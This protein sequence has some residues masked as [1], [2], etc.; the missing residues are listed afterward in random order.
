[1]RCFVLAAALLISW[2]ASQTGASGPEAKS[3][4]STPNAQVSS[5]HP[6]SP[7]GF[8]LLHT[9]YRFEND[10]TGEKE[11]VARVRVLDYTEALRWS[12]VSFGYSPSRERIQILYLRIQK[13]D[14]TVVNV[15][16][17]RGPKPRG[18]FREGGMPGFDYADKRVAVPALSPG[19]ALEYD[20]ETIFPTALAPGQFWQT[21]SFQAVPDEELEVNIPS[22]RLVKVKT[23]LA[24]EGTVGEENG[25]RIYRWKCS[26]LL[27]EPDTQGGTKNHS[28]KEIPDVQVSSF[29]TW[30]EVG[31]WYADM[32]KSRRVPSPEV[33]AKADELTEGLTSNFDKVRALY[34]FVSKKV[35]YL[36]LVS[37]GI[38]GY[39][40]HS[41][42]EVL[43][44][45]YG[46]CKDKDTLL[47]ALLEAEGLRTSSVLMNPLRE[48]DPDVPSPWP[49]THVIT[50]L[51]LGKDEIW[52][53]TSTPFLPFRTLP[54][55]LRHT[56]G[57][58]IPPDG[59]PHF[60]EP[61]SYSAERPNH[62]D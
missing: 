14:G 24:V 28:E 22:A 52:M 48:L 26:R 39:E 36:S 43:Q 17:N 15:D 12:E 21:Y 35:R 56:K 37:L 51:P 41:A 11:V 57:L 46:D 61:R 27:S 23:K 5:S 40:P 30:E 45:R 34:N 29:A 7:S 20:V 42:R 53:D 59:A 49:F 32:E 18:I 54:Y 50:M 47:A 9:R 16:T 62:V 2:I 13:K 25:R 38:G 1:M 4:S 31:R 44:T 8:E 55:Q 58:A 10:G 6:T 3:Q 19:D 33:R 60:A